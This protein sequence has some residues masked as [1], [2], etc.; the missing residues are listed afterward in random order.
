[1]KNFV[2]LLFASCFLQ[3]VNAQIPDHVYKESIQSVR[4]YKYGDFYSYP[5][6]MLNSGEQLELHFD[7]LDADIKNFYYTYQLC[8]ADW[9]PTN[10]YPQDYIRGFMSTRIS[11]YRN[12]SVSLTRYTHYYAS[13][14]DRNSMPSQSGN[15]LLKV[16][17]NSD[18]SKLFFTKRF[19]VVDNKLAVAAQIRQP[20]S[21]DMYNSGQRVTIA[22]NTANAKINTFSPQDIKLVVLQ[23]NIWPTA[24]FVDR[25]S[26]YRGNYFEYS[27]DAT[28]FF[29]GR[30][31][32]WIDLR[33]L[34]LMSDRMDKLIDTS[35]RIDVYVKA[36]A[37]RRNTVYIYQQDLNGR[38]YIDNRDGYNPFWQSDYAYVHFTY[39]PPGG[40]AY[41][42]KDIY[43]FGEITNYEAN[44]SS[45]MIYNNEKGVYEKTLFLKQGYY[46][47]SYITVDAGKQSSNRFSFANTEGNFTNTEN[48][49]TVLVYYRPFGARA[50]ALIGMAQLNTIISR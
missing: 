35:K 2:F 36:D 38:Y 8:N 25:P 11:T 29:G 41:A 48:N 44:E 16:F 39:V 5:I 26:I 47:Y 34:Q 6:I 13:L 45:R 10:L 15:Y 21:P 46:N 28:S 19:M 4:L 32:R 43:L 50:D 1:M 20:Y 17:L 9:T 14:P 12:S 40:Q 18:T 49:Y 31:W 24:A 22:L 42:G 27:D 3:S 30:E 33:S 37:E 7:D 23:N